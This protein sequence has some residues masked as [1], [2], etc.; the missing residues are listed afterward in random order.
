MSGIISS[1]L[2]SYRGVG[3]EQI[4]IRENRRDYQ[5]RTI[6]RHWHHREHKTQDTGRRQTKRPHKKQTNKTKKK[7]T[8]LVS[9]KTPV[10]L[11]TYS[12]RTPM[13]VPVHVE[14]MLHYAI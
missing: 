9:Y 3:A 2:V 10:M 14:M 8:V 5:Q 1:T 7:K 12:R 6:Y 13:V 11:F 4:N